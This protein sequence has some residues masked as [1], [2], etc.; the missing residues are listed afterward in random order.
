[1]SFIKRSYNFVKRYLFKNPL[2][3]FLYALNFWRPGFVF[4]ANLLSEAELIKEI[5]K[6][7]SLIRMGDGEISL[8]LGLKNHY[9]N[10]S[11]EL[12]RAMFDIVLGYKDNSPYILS[13]PRFI[14]CTNDELHGMGKF[15]VWMPLKVMFLLYFNKS[16]SYLD[17]HSFYYDGYFERTVGP[18]IVAKKVIL[19]TKEETIRKQE[20]NPNIPWTDFQSVVVPSEESLSAYDVI[21][22]DIEK[23]LIGLDKKSV[24]LL[25]AMGPVGKILALEYAKLGVQSIDIGK[26]AEVMYTGESIAYIV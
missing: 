10:F 18:A 12:K 9:Q 5:E 16:T 1:M 7:K 17:A 15:Q 11:P 13:I 25:F 26:V 4:K 23:A 24:V 21:K 22:A 20:L 19:I 14:N 8:M 3:I 2:Y 6:G